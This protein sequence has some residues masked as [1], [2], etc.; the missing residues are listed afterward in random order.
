[1]TW[2]DL[3]YLVEVKRHKTL[4]RAAT[5]LG[6]NVATVSRRMDR[7]AQALG[8]PAMIRTSDGWTPSPEI[9]HLLA[10]AEDFDHRIEAAR[11]NF[12]GGTGTVS[13]TIGAAPV[14]LSRI[15]FPH[16]PI[17]RDDAPELELE[18]RNRIFESG[19]GDCDI[20]LL[21]SR[22]ESGRLIA[23]RI[24]DLPIGI[25][26][27]PQ[28]DL[29]GDWIGMPDEYERFGP[30]AMAKA[31]FG[32]PPRIRVEQIDQIADLIEATRTM[33][34]LPHV[35]AA[36]YPHLRLLSAPQ[37]DLIASVYAAYHASRRGDR[38]LEVVL[39]WMRTAFRTAATATPPAPSA[40]AHTVALHDRKGMFAAL[41]LA[42][43]KSRP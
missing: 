19:L 37:D 3:R 26:A 38:T 35:V 1:M 13:L 9:A 22:P 27:H 20:V 7:I 24:A 36:K 4:T 33:G 28:A 39:D 40:A 16:L 14:L 5:A 25:Y 21:R 34:P 30:Q 32:R 12:D 10:I 11:N 18:F 15:L 42:P 31:W 29:A 23:A 8:H 41:S 2:D 6:T 43:A 17:L